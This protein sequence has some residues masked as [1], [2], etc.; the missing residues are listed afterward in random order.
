MIATYAEVTPLPQKKHVVEEAVIVQ[1]DDAAEAK[2]AIAEGDAIVSMLREEAHD[3]A[4]MRKS[5]KLEFRK[6]KWCRPAL[7]TPWW[8][9]MTEE[10]R[11]CEEQREREATIEQQMAVLTNV[12]NKTRELV[13]KDERTR[14]L[15]KRAAAELV[16]GCYLGRR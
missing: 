11:D 1:E 7:T 6:R 9:S 2:K 14:K 4:R 12:T 5:M 15:H 10:E 3:K 16:P 8:P 13:T